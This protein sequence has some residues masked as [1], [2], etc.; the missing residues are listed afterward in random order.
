MEQQ[1]PIEFHVHILGRTVRHDTEELK[2]TVVQGIFDQNLKSNRGSSGMVLYSDRIRFKQQGY[3]EYIHFSEISHFYESTE[4]PEIFMLHVIDKPAN[5]SYYESYQCQSSADVHSIRDLLY[6]AAKSPVHL[7][8][9]VSVNNRSWSSGSSCSSVHRSVPTTLTESERQQRSDHK[10]GT[11]FVSSKVP[12]SHAPY[13]I[14]VRPKFEVQSPKLVR[15]V[16]TLPGV[17]DRASRSQ[18]RTRPVTAYRAVSV[19]RTIRE[20]SINSSSSRYRTSVV[21]E[22]YV[23][24]TYQRS[25]SVYRPLSVQSIPSQ[26]TRYGSSRRSGRKEPLVIYG[27]R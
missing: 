4:R 7:F 12:P 11:R 15:Q 17:Q 5:R 3:R 20:P 22:Q 1:L 10:N 21:T 19:P 2:D 9:E 8:R 24:V 6:N 13:F 18:V 23:P 25:R 26:F 16:H 27:P 14:P